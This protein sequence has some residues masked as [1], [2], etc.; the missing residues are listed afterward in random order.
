MQ[1]DERF[2]K[3]QHASEG[4]F[5]AHPLGAMVF[6]RAG[7]ILAVNSQ[8]LANSGVELDRLVGRKVPEVFAGVMQRYGIEAPYRRLVEEGRPLEI[9]I[10]SYEPEYVKKRARFRAWGFTI[11]P[12]QLFAILTE[13]TDLKRA[14]APP[15][16]MGASALMEPVYRFIERAARV[17]TTVLLGGESGTGKELVA[18]AVHAR[19]NRARKPFLAL[20]CAALPGSLLESTLF[21][22]EK[23][24]FTG[25]DRQTKGYFEAAEGGTLLLDEI[26]ETTLELQAKLLRVLQ[27]G[28][29]TRV[30]GTEPLHTDV[31]VI[32]A[33]NR[34]LET[35]VAAR[36][37]REDLYF[38][39]NILRI[40]LPPLR[41]RPEDLPLLTQ[42]FLDQLERKHH[43]GRKHVTPEVLDTFLAYRWPGNVRELANVLEAAYVTSPEQTLSL[44]H[45]PNRIR[46]VA[47][48]HPKGHFQ[49][50]AYREALERFR[51]DYAAQILACAGGDMRKA[52]QLAGVDPSTLYRFGARS[53]R[54]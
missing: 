54:E 50:H 18:R 44:E 49:P 47:L 2:L 17:N 11:V 38:R 30:G 23:G 15:E 33:T 32:C 36:R 45:L 52:A 12:G 39:I 16:I 20:N 51:R 41:Q 27:D 53:G 5:A 8:Q 22:N 26:G 25:A 40:E 3:I 21:G 10:E 9:H 29:V 42:H 35:E 4:F 19:S 28:V 37:F 43:L 48:L 6:D 31:R 7:T 24:A 14:E 46:E 1:S 13:G 34:D